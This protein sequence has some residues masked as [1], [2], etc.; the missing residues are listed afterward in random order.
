MISRKPLKTLML[1]IAVT[2]LTGCG[3]QQ[4]KLDKRAEI[5]IGAA[6]S[7]KPTIK[8]IAEEFERT[9]GA[10]VTLS[11]GSSGLLARQIENGAPIDLFI[12]ADEEYIYQLKKKK[13]TSQ[14]LPYARGFAVFV[15]K[16]KT[17]T[18]LLSPMITKIAIANP[19]LAPYGRAGIEILKNNGTWRTTN[20]KIVYADN[21]AQAYEFVKTGNADVGIVALSLVKKTGDPYTLINRRAYNPII[22]WAAVNKKTDNPKTAKAFLQFMRSPFAKKTLTDD[23]FELLEVR[24]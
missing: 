19:K 3:A 22:S 1:V 21:V 5:T 12:A 23:G 13:K 15:G 16:A 18:D 4:Y 10:N 17:H 9:T 2:L 11:Y 8:A 14:S 24:K 7:M 20:K 6:A